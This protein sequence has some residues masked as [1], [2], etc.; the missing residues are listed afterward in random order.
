HIR[1]YPQTWYAAVQRLLRQTAIGTKRPIVD[2][3]L[4][5]AVMALRYA[6]RCTR[7]RF[8]HLRQSAR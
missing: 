1:A 2:F 4:E 5:I 6:Q 8:I 7:R 3:G